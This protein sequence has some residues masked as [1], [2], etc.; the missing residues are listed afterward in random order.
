M[1]QK[2]TVFVFLSAIFAFF[3][4]VCVLPKDEKASVMENRPLA[5]MPEVSAKNIFSGDFTLEFEDYLTDNVAFRSSFVKF[6]TLIE[7]NRG[8]HLKSGGRTVD[9]PDGTKLVLNDGKIMEV[10]TKNPDSEAMYIDTLNSYSQKFSD[11]I[12]L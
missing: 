8:I 2:I 9:L 7:E 4:L 5:Q 3:L 11:K 12:N 1:R 10:Y 6:G